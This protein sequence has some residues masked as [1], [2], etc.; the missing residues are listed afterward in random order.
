MLAQREAANKAID[1]SSDDTVSGD[2]DDDDD[3]EEPSER[4]KRRRFSDTLIQQRMEE[5]RERVNTTRPEGYRMM[6]RANTTPTS[7]NVC[8]KISGRFQRRSRS[9]KTPSLTKRGMRR[10]T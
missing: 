3:D 9:R 2:D 6:G 1:E 10:V 7:I 8:A 4:Q 5:D